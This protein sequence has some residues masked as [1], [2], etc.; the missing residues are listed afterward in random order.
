MQSMDPRAEELLRLPI[1]GQLGFYGLDGYPRVLPV[2]F[3]YDRGEFLI[4]SPP[5]AYKGRALRADGR[6]SMTVSTP[7]A[8]YHVVTAQADA[9]VELL[10]EAERI[11][12]VGRQ[13]NRYL[14]P[15]GGRAYLERWGKGGHPGDGEL[16]RL[17]PR[18]LRFQ[19]I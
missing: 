2:W 19:E 4:A 5:G 6:A 8:P 1:V 14:G 11:R 13:A 10:P 18:R 9:V 15:A 16:I 3:D 7:H 12:F 17:R